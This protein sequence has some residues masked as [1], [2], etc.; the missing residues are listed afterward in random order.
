MSQR[1][2]RFNSC[3]EHRRHPRGGTA[4]TPGLNPGA[5]GHEGSS[6]SGGIRDHDLL[7]VL[8]GTEIRPENL[9]RI[10]ALTGGGAG[11]RRTQAHPSGPMRLQR[12]GPLTLQSDNQNAVI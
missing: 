10:A 9:D 7:E 5:R 11:H 3:P 2:C 4:D 12:G 6:P 8:S 1:T